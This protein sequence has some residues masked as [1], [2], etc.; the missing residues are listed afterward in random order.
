[1]R[2]YGG[3]CRAT[4][5]AVPDEGH[6]CVQVSDITTC[7]KPAPRPMRSGGRSGCG[8]GAPFGSKSINVADDKIAHD[9]SVG[10]VIASD[11][12]LRRRSGPGPGRQVPGCGA[13]AERIGTSAAPT[14][15]PE[16]KADAA[17]ARNMER[18]VSGDQDH[19]VRHGIKS[20]GHVA[21]TAVHRNDFGHFFLLQ[22]RLPPV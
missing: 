9:N 15:A 5:M 17:G 22:Q 3:T 7:L 6:D 18:I 14:W 10:D 12:H 1:M 16:G 4:G 13:G 11:Q 21:I 8:K 2:R 20:C 19:P